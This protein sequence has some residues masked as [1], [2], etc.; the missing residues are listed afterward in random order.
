MATAT[1]TV[2]A[3]APDR[4]PT[5][6]ELL[7][8][9]DGVERD[10]IRGELRERPMT[11][12][13]LW[14][15]RIE[16]RIGTVLENWLE[17]QPEPR[18]WVVAGEA[19]FRLIRDPETTVG[20]DVAYVSAEVV[21]RSLAGAFFDGPPV[22]AVEILSPSDQQGDIDEKVGLY[23]TAGTA[24]VWV[25]NPTLQTITI[26]RPDAPPRLVAEPD[27]LDAAPHLPGFAV[28]VARLFG[29]RR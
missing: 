23:L 5:N 7:Q 19:G 24:L 6:E 28:P 13:N 11:R 18:G 2:P 16:I 3:P 27:T 17:T 29:P 14:H 26:Y 1:A 20:V 22:L 4:P 12:R 25:V 9:E 10:I 8:L 21:A 15:S